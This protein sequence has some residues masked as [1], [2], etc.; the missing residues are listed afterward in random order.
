MVLPAP[1][2]ATSATQS[3]GEESEDEVQQLTVPA[4][5]ELQHL[6]PAKLAVWR[7]F[8]EQVHIAVLHLKKLSDTME[9]LI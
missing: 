7:L 1:H 2:L 6:Q 5:P 8:M 3:A 9:N 4:L